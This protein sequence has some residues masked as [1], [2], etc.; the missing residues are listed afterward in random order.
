MSRE[1]VGMVPGKMLRTGSFSRS[2]R[3]CIKSCQMLL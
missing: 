1:F 2:F 3:H